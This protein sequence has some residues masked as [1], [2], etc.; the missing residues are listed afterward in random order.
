MNANEIF[1]IRRF[2]NEFRRVC[3]TQWEA[4]LMCVLV[5][6]SVVVLG[7]LFLQYQALQEYAFYADAG[8][9]GVADRIMSHDVPSRQNILFNFLFISLGCVS[10]S[11]MLPGL[12]TKQTRTMMLTTPSSTFEKFLVQWTMCVPCFIVVFI[13][14]TVIADVLRLLFFTIVTRGNVEFY[15]SFHYIASDVHGFYDSCLSYF[16]IYLLFTSLYVVGATVWHRSSFLKITAF[17]GGWGLLILLWGYAWQ[18]YFN[19]D[20]R[21]VWKMVETK[22]DLLINLS[23]VVIAIANWMIAYKRLKETEV[24]K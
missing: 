23:I 1:D 17:I 2:G 21:Q 13:A 24:V 16:L 5:T 20:L 11:L 14:S 4:T 3:L 6:L 18:S 15:T 9:L 7:A 12:A 19:S 22:V 10:A 8:K